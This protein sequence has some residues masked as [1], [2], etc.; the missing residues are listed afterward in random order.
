[1]SN[2]LYTEESSGV[3]FGHHGNQK[4]NQMERSASIHKSTGAAFGLSTDPLVPKPG[5]MTHREI[6]QLFK[7]I[8]FGG[9]SSIFFVISTVIVKLLTDLSPSELAIFRFIGILLFSIPVAIRYKLKNPGESLFGPSTL[10]H[11]MILRGIMGA[12]SLLLRFYAYRYLPLAD[13]SVIVF[14]VP[15]FVTFTAWMFLN[16]SVDHSFSLKRTLLK[17]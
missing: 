15:V 14:S 11:I 4:G 1:M 16:V 5:R 9:S 10:F 12:S 17:F 7:G 2:K 13:A 3:G 8:F 6:V